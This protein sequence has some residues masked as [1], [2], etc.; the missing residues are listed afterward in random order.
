[1]RH[2]SGVWSWITESSCRHQPEIKF[3]CVGLILSYNCGYRGQKG[4]KGNNHV[5]ANLRKMVE[6]YKGNQ[7]KLKAENCET[8]RIR[9]S[10]NDRFSLLD[11]GS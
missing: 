4:L 10:S 7:K 9:I 3:N 11:S 2:H 8:H 1:M 6:T 5:N